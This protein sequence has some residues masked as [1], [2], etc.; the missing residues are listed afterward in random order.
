MELLRDIFYTPVYNL[1]F[2]F[3]DVFPGEHLWVGIVALTL[4]IKVILLPLSAKAVRAQRELAV[5]QPKMDEL[6]EKYKDD[7]EEMNK[8]M[9]GLYQEHNINPLSG[10]LPILIQMPILIILYRVVIDGISGAHYNLLYSFVSTP[11]NLNTLFL[12]QDLSKPSI[13]LAIVAGLFQ[14]LQTWQIQSNPQNKPKNS[15]NKTTNRMMYLLPLLTI[16]FGVGL[17]AALM[18]YWIANTIFSMVQQAYLM[19]LHPNVHDQDKDKVQ[20]SVRSK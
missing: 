16:L 8:K 1:L 17:P 18:I 15:T 4:I 2:W 14:L 3:V 5:L 20:V 6:R 19:R 12:G 7:P 9:I 13:I 10:C 11:N